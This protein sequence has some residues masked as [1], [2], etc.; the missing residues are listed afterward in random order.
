MPRSTCHQ[1][2]QNRECTVFQPSVAHR[3]SFFVQYKDLK[4]V[5]RG[6]RV[7]LLYATRVHCVTVIFV[8]II[9]TKSIGNSPRVKHRWR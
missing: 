9:A 8:Q 2:Y 1:C 7:T 3:E 4:V 5:L 6:G